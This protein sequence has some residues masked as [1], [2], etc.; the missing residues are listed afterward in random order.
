MRTDPKNTA[1]VVTEGAT[2]RDTGEEVAK[3]GDRVILTDREREA[4]RK[5]AFASLEK[6]IEDRAQ[7][8]QA[9][10]RIDG[11]M[12]ISAR[13]WDDPYTQNQKLRKAFRVGRKEREREAEATEGL[14]DRMSLGIDLL[15][16]TKEDAQRA[17]LVD[18]APAEEKGRDKALSKPLFGNAKPRSAPAGN[19]PKGKLKSEKEAER[20]KESLVSELMGNTRAA[21]DPFLL[22]NR[23]GESK[24]L[25]RIPGVKRKRDIQEEEKPQTK[26]VVQ[27]SN[28][29]IGLVNY[30]SD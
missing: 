13:Q 6:T 12:D 30:D 24:I 19:T 8:K 22:E 10:E 23:G 2:K 29:K 9:T 16:G 28:S 5:N 17:A 25:S 14:K 1:Y 21:K 7:L 15:P 3:E 4:L 26:T 18:F 11:L 27:E 20:R